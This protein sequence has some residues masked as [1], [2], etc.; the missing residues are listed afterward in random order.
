MAAEKLALMV[1]E[2]V[3]GGKQ[4]KNKKMLNKIKM[5][6]EAAGIFLLIV[7]ASFV[8]ASA[9]IKI[10]MKDSF[11][12][13]EK[14]SFNYTITGNEENILYAPTINCLDTPAP[15]L[16]ILNCTLPIT[17]SYTYLIVDEATEPQTCTAFVSIIS[18]YEMQE[19]KSFIIIS[20]PSFN[21][22]ILTCEEQT[23]TNQ[24]KVFIKGKNIYLNYDSEISNIIATANLTYPDRTTKQLTL[25]ASIKAEQIGT[26][27]LEVNAV[28]SGYKPAN[29][30]TQFGVIEK[31]AH[32]G[33]TSLS[34]LKDMNKRDATVKTISY[35]AI[36]A[37]I[38]AIGIVLFFVIRKR[39]K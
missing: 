37:V 38:L 36:G 5:R 24:T 12:E 3:T 31:E 13:G 32:I 30:K 22:Q 8:S 1:Q 10:D 39:R 19:E 6:K 34:D 26:Y 17:D 33:Y 15:A 14:I 18:P 9:S 28:K 4:V 16:N 21:F 11:S 23:C 7:V 20:N 25:P 2:T 35:S 27:N 29:E